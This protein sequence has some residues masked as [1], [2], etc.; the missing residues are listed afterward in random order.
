MSETESFDKTA[1]HGA[2]DSVD[3]EF[4]IADAHS[5][6]MADQDFEL[7]AEHATDKYLL[8]I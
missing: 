5:T 2:A 6:P 3:S 7:G 8:T 1:V 4:K